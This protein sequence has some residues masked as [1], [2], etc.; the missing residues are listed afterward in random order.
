MP[1]DGSQIGTVNNVAGYI[2]YSNES[3]KEIQSLR[4][5]TG[6]WLSAN[7]HVNFP[8]RT[9]HELIIA[10]K[11]NADCLVFHGSPEDQFPAKIVQEKLLIQ[12]RL[13]T[14]TGDVLLTSRYMLVLKNN[15][16]LFTEAD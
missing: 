6:C 4:V 16:F 15:E 13:V 10:L 1:L 11:T 14:N 3:G 9:K 5:Q 12:V 7:E 8:P 2:T